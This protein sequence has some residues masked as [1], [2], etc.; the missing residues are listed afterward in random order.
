MKQVLIMNLNTIQNY[1]SSLE[2]IVF[3]IVVMISVFLAVTVYANNPRSATNKIFFLLSLFTA[4]WLIAAYVVKLPIFSS[5]QLF[6]ARLGIFFAAPMS[7]LFFLLAHTLPYEKLQLKKNTFILV[8]Y[9]TILMMGLNISPY[10]FTSVEII[11]GTVNP[12]PGIG[13]IPFAVISTLFS[14]LAVYFLFKRIKSSRDIEKRQLRL[15]L[16]GILLMLTLVIGTVLVPIML[17]SSGIFLPLIPIYTLIFL[18]MTAYA[19]VKHQLFNMKVLV[20][21]ALTLIIWIVLFAKIFS[22]QSIEAKVVDALT[23]AFTIIFGIFLV[24]SVR[25]EVET[26][27]KIQRLAQDLS[28]ANKELKKLDQLKSDFLS[29]ATHQLRGPLSTIK[30]YISMI[31]EGSYGAISERLSGILKK[32]YRSNEKLVGLVNDFLNLSR[33]E[34]G[35]MEYHFAK[36]SV[37][38]VVEEVI[39]SLQENAKH[40]GLK[41]IWRKP[42]PPMPEITMDA[43]KIHEVIYNLVDNA[44]KYTQR[45]QVEISAR[46]TNHALR[47]VVADTGI[48]LDE[49]EITTLFQRFRRAGRASTVHVGG[50]GIGLYMAK[51]IVEAHGGK[52]WAESPG[53]HQGSTFFVELPLK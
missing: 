10:A 30:G 23:L 43:G 38:D 24:R 20:T 32:V 33:I 19:I 39:D 37:E 35:R 6:L 52:I 25:K 47:I 13:L 45:G 4:F 46:K 8:I 15:V 27:E 17:F 29:F 28:V 3:I 2:F 48:G 21:Q 22:V 11:N 18:G 34:E 26:R 42:V 5:E 50:V 16:I 12:T 31:L 7:A 49:D 14:A 53:Q 1:T 36:A 40:K 41:L 44:I 51:Y 9:A